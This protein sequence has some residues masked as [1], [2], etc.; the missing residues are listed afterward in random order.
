MNTKIILVVLGE[1][2]SVFSELLFKYFNST[3]FKKNQN[4]IVLIG[5][6]DLLLKQMKKLGYDFVFNEITNI[7]NS[8]KKVINILNKPC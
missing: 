2:N 6:K 7:K 1:P 3:K 4:K 8:S 5:S